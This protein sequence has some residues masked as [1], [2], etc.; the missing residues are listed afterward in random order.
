MYKIIG[1]INGENENAND[2]P[3]WA[4]RSLLRSLFLDGDKN[5]KP[6][7]DVFSTDKKDKK[8]IKN[9]IYQPPNVRN[10]CVKLIKKNIDFVIKMFIAHI[11]INVSYTYQKIYELN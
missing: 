6:L 5:V 9:E 3:T 7:I 11:K 1:I 10:K 8:S 2:L 4:K